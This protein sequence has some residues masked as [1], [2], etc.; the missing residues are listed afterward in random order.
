MNW[1]S[2][3]LWEVGFLIETEYLF[4]HL[5]SKYLLSTYYVLGIHLYVWETAINKTKKSPFQ[6]WP[7]WLERPVTEGLQV[8]FS[9]GAHT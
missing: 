8:H 3:N 1:A 5:F 7:S 4:I 6:V 9:V 2:V